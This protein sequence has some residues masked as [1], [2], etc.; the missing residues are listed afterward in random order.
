MQYVNIIYYV[1]YVNIVNKMF[2]SFVKVKLN[3]TVTFWPEFMQIYCRWFVQNNL[4]YD[5]N[6]CKIM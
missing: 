6:I 5:E 1:C 3:E 2:S 4:V